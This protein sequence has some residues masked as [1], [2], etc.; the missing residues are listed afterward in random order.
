MQNGWLYDYKH[1]LQ[2]VSKNIGRQADIL[3]DNIYIS[4]VVIDRDLYAVDS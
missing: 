2:N 1:G 3:Y 4:L